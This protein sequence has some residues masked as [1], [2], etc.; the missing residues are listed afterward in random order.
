MPPR[1]FGWR[2]GVVDPSGFGAPPYHSRIAS[3]HRSRQVGPPRLAPPLVAASQP[4]LSD[5]RRPRS[6]CA[7]IPPD[8]SIS[9]L[10]EPSV[11]RTSGSS[12]SPPPRRWTSPTSPVPQP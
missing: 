4:F 12:P 6:S 7:S 8:E 9:L 5:P 2:V 3:E 1:G 10:S 11:T